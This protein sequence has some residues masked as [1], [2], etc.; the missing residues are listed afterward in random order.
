[1]KAE[2]SQNG[3]GGGEY[4]TTPS[5]LWPVSLHTKL[6]AKPGQGGR[7]VRDPIASQAELYRSDLEPRTSVTDMRVLFGDLWAEQSGH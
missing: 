7:G 2:P 1:M 4:P 5:P 6:L 3:E